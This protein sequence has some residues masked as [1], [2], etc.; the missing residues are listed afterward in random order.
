MYDSQNKLLSIN[1]FQDEYVCGEFS[2]TGIGIPEKEA[3]NIFN[4]FF[5][6]KKKITERI[7]DEPVGSG[8]GLYTCM[9]L[10]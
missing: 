9:S 8:L 3:E 1:V 4:P 10:I 5:S 7:M 6:K 2:D